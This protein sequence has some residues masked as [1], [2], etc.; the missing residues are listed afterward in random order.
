MRSEKP[1]DQLAKLILLS[2]VKALMQRN[3]TPLSYDCMVK[4]IQNSLHERLK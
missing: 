2:Y 4:N 1:I 3:F